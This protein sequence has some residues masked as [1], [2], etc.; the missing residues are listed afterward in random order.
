[1]PKSVQDDLFNELT[2]DFFDSPENAYV[3]QGDYVRNN[4]ECFPG[5]RPGVADEPG[6]AP[7]SGGIT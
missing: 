4:R 5:S 2:G 3:F 6:V 7:D 1:L